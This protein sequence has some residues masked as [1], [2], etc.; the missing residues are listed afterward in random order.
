MITHSL[1][2][3]TSCI[4]TFLSVAILELARMEERTYDQIEDNVLL[5]WVSYLEQSDCEKLLF[6]FLLDFFFLQ[7]IRILD[8]RT[9]KWIIASSNN[10]NFVS[11][12]LYI[13]CCC[14]CCCCYCCCY[15]FTAI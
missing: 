10:T 2:G 6:S 8:R 4:Q 14:C 9:F 11:N 5:Q 7:S 12:N 1:V 3:T 13:C 15:L